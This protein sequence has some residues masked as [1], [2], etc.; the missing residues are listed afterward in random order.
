MIRTIHPRPRELRSADTLRR[1]L[2][3]A[4]QRKPAGGQPVKLF[5]RKRESGV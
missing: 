2:N 4:E 1:E 3:A 5:R